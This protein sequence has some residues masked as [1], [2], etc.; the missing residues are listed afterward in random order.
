MN[1]RR[2]HPERLYN[3]CIYQFNYWSISIYSILVICHGHLAN[4]A[5]LHFTL[6]N[7]LNKLTNTV[8]FSGTIIL[9]KRSLYLLLI[10]HVNIDLHVQRLTKT[11]YSIQVRR[12]GHYHSH[13][14]LIHIKRNNLIL[15]SNIT[16][17]S[18]HNIIFNR[19]LA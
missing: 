12:V 17:D 6:R 5:N 13:T 16:R 19:L 14:K 4:S 8:I 18:R 1:I 10:C 3:Q 15:V 2:L 7:V 11:I 9:L